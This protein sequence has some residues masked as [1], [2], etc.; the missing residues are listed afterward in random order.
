[1]TAHR[2]A[3]RVRLASGTAALVLVAVQAAAQSSAPG[4]RAAQSLFGP[5]RSQ[6]AREVT[7]DWWSTLL[8]AYDGRREPAAAGTAPRSTYFVADESVTFGRRGDSISFGGFTRAELRKYRGAD[9]PIKPGVTGLAWF[10][11]GLGARL[12]LRALGAYR[13]TPFRLAGLLPEDPGTGLGLD[14]GVDVTPIESLALTR[15]RVVSR[16]G[17]L[18]AAYD[19]TPLTRL[20]AFVQQRRS[21]AEEGAR[22][23]MRRVGAQ[24]ARHLSA[25]TQ[26]VIGYALRRLDRLDIAERTDS[27]DLNVG[28]DYHRA[29]SFTRRTTLAFHTGSAI[30]RREHG[31]SLRAIGEATIRREFRR[32]WAAEGGYSRRVL[33]L[34]GFEQP[35]FA[36]SATFNVSGLLTRR[37]DVALSGRYAV[38]EIGLA[39]RSNPFDLAMATARLRWSVGSH[40]ALFMRG[41]YF[42]YE[43]QDNAG[44]PPGLARVLNRPTAQAG[45][46]LWVPFLDNGR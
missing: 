32:S 27:H 7:L 43:F 42:Y 23:D 18:E 45:V 4:Q 13:D 17:A 9:E 15:H 16:M 37:L 10:E 31:T 1:M 33:F 5:G 14:A 2:G 29:L 34:E 12:K 25:H 24:I 21:D 11:A 44:L 6:T 22:H 40:V 19:V 20:T 26:L 36:D 39:V 30:L 35:A 38:G 28:I 46:S 8:A 3:R 41:G